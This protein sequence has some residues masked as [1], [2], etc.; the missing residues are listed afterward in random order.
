MPIYLYRCRQ[1]GHKFEMLRA[2]SAKDSELMCPECGARA[3]E[4]VI[5]PFY[6]R[7]PGRQGG[8]FSFG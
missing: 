1:C 8:A 7:N 5:M 6:G 2:M 3:P 4:K